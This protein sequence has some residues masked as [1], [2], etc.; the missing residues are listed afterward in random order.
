METFNDVINSGQLVLDDFFATWCGP[1]K[2]MHPVLEQLK[3]NLGDRLRIMKMEKADKLCRRMT[4]KFKS[5]LMYDTICRLFLYLP[6]LDGQRL[7]GESYAR[8]DHFAAV[9]LVRNGIAL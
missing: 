1:C 3:A 4:G 8:L 6:V 7:G 5:S 2:A 9:C